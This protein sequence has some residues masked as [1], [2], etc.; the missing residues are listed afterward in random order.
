MAEVI[1][2][3]GIGCRLVRMGIQDRFLHGASRP[4][5]A[6]ENRMD[7]MSLVREI[8]KMARKNPSA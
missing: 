5:L 6:K 2:E 4:T 8:E 3:K 1:A 7:G